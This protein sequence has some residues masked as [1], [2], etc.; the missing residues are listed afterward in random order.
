MKI[1]L[2]NSRVQLLLQNKPSSA[3]INSI[4]DFQL[5]SDDE[6]QRIFTKVAGL[7]GVKSIDEVSTAKRKRLTP[8]SMSSFVTYSQAPI[9]T[10][11]IDTRNSLCVDLYEAIDATSQAI[12]DR[13]DQED[14]RR[15]ID[16]SKC[17]I[18]AANKEAVENLKDKLSFIS[19]LINLDELTEELSELPVYIKIFNKEAAIPLRKVTKIDT[20]CEIMASKECLPQTHKLLQMYC[21]TFISNCK[22]YV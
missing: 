13:F 21:G 16:I 14:L 15:L 19:D 7:K 10:T 4:S 9:E 11:N 3:L 2:G 17:L 6:F 22:T 5:R 18:G 12:K 8:S 20:I 1:T